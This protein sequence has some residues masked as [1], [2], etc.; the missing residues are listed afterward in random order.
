VIY[1]KHWTRSP[2]GRVITYQFDGWFLF[3]IVPLYI[4]RTR[5]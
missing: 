1:R 5:M 2:K 4:H 3:G